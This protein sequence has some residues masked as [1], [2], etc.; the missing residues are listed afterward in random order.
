M[1]DLDLQKVRAVLGVEVELYEGSFFETCAVCTRVPTC[2]I[3]SYKY[4]DEHGVLIIYLRYRAMTEGL[5]K[6]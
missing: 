4:C 3:G 2:R 6:Y 1:A 5:I